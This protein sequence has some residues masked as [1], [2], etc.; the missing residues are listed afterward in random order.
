MHGAALG[1]KLGIRRDPHVRADVARGERTVE[2]TLDVFG[3]TDRHRRF[4]D[5]DE[6]RATLN[7]LGDLFSGGVDVLQVGVAVGFGRRPDGDKHDAFAAD[8]GDV[9]LKPQVVFGV[10]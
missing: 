1:E 8:L 9:G 2:D 6:F 10:G 5:H 4:I 7:L 3:A